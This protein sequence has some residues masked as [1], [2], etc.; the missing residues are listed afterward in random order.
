M[1]ISLEASTATSGR[2]SAVRAAAGAGGLDQPADTRA[3]YPVH[4]SLVPHARLMPSIQH[5]DVLHLV[6]RVEAVGGVQHRRA[7]PVLQFPQRRR[8]VRE[9]PTQRTNARLDVAF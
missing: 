2:R 8:K 5:R 6:E 9:R 3:P 4:A 7:G 1:I